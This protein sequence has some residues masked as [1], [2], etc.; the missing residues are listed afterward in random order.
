MGL[1]SALKGLATKFQSRQDAFKNISDISAYDEPSTPVAPKPCVLSG[2][3]IS[4]IDSKKPKYPSGSAFGETNFGCANAA[5]AQSVFIDTD[6]ES[7]R[8]HRTLDTFFESD[9]EVD[10]DAEAETNA[11][12]ESDA[13]ADNVRTG[14]R[15]I[16]RAWFEI[17]LDKEKLARRVEALEAEREAGL[18]FLQHVRT[19]GMAL[20]DHLL[21]QSNG[22]DAYAHDT[23]VLR[24]TI[25]HLRE[26]SRAQQIQLDQTL[27]ASRTS[28]G[29]FQQAYRLIGGLTEQNTALRSDLEESRAREEAKDATISELRGDFLVQVQGFESVNLLLQQEKESSKESETQWKRAYDRQAQ[30][31]EETEEELRKA[32]QEVDSLLDQLVAHENKSETSNGDEVERLQETIKDLQRHVAYTERQRDACKAF[33]KESASAQPSS[34]GN[35]ALKDNFNLVIDENVD[36]R[37]RLSETQYQN[38]DLRHFLSGHID[39]NVE[40]AIDPANADPRDIARFQESE[41][42]IQ[43]LQQQVER[44]VAGKNALH[45]QSDDLR[46]ALA[47]KGGR[48]RCYNERKSTLSHNLEDQHKAEVEKLQHELSEAQ[49]SDFN[50]SGLF[51]QEQLRADKLEKDNKILKAVN[52][53]DLKLQ[54]E[55]LEQVHRR[56][57]GDDKAIVEGLH[58][59]ELNERDKLLETYY[60]EIGE[61]QTTISNLQMD[62]ANNTCT[63]YTQRSENRGLRIVGARNKEIVHAMEQRFGAELRAKP[64]LVDLR[65]HRAHFTKDEME[66]LAE[67]DERL[68]ELVGMEASRSGR[69]RYDDVMDQ[70][71]SR[72]KVE[73][74]ER[75]ESTVV[76]ISMSLVAGF[77]Y[78]LKYLSK[79][80]K[81]FEFIYLIIEVVFLPKLVF[82]FVLISFYQ[83]VA[84]FSACALSQNVSTRMSKRDGW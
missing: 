47:S 44:E 6:N 26:R 53:R 51:M 41:R 58:R 27:E 78:R 25:A 50:H 60:R 62:A 2:E 32:N 37:Q 21:A 71:G 57:Y 7:V 19:Y 36:L 77:E 43:Y 38:A 75:G 68:Y 66:N 24:E 67:V 15:K 33:L 73:G 54:K 64:M 79:H 4:S 3:F 48:M 13:E 63:I 30:E 82:L 80:D 74:N 10:T 72:C 61:L 69:G 65:P 70:A 1:R 12:A 59:Q 45:N 76:R 20:S 84:M 52:T 35:E 18:R 17:M 16:G 55:L 11:E 14:P 34:S 31:L 56:A 39:Q 49:E 5:T 42:C 46:K 8:S 22:L 9:A 40:R 23:L 83:F 28:E 29:I 81:G